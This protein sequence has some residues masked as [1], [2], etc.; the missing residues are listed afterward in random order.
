MLEKCLERG[1]NVA[2]ERAKAS[3]SAEAERRSYW[4]WIR[5]FSQTVRLSQLIVLLIVVV[6]YGAYHFTT[7][8]DALTRKAKVGWDLLFNKKQLQEDKKLRWVNKQVLEILRTSLHISD[9]EIT[10]S[11]DVTFVKESFYEIFPLYKAVET[12]NLSIKNR[13]VYHFNF[14]EM[15]ILQVLLEKNPKHL[16]EVD[17]HILLADE[18]MNSPDNTEDDFE[19]YSRNS[20]QNFANHLEFIT[21]VLRQFYHPNDENKKL[22]EEKL[23][24][25]GGCHALLKK[26]MKLKLIYEVTQC[27]RL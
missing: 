3:F 8:N 16:P 23:N 2:E 6:L 7:Q 9:Y 20:I 22:M 27:P 21:S 17:K 25:F 18:L 12:S 19:Y 1:I 14:A 13:V 4:G 24:I 15:S 10:I 5:N 11:N 26:D